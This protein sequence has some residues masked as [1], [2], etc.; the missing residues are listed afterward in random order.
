MTKKN[1]VIFAVFTLISAIFSFLCAGSFLNF[2][3]AEFLVAAFVCVVF[4]ACTLP[5]GGICVALSVAAAFLGGG[6]QGVILA[7]VSGIFAA[8][9]GVAIKKGITTGKLVIIF[10]SGLFFSAIAFIVYKTNITDPKFVENFLNA[11]KSDFIYVAVQY[12]EII[13]VEGQDAVISQFADTYFMYVQNTI[14]AILIIVSLIFAF[15]SSCVVSL[16]LRVVKNRELYKVTFSKFMCDK[17][18]T[19]VFAI[20]AVCFFFM[21]QSI[22]QTVFMNAFMILLFVFQVCGYSLIDSFLKRKNLP[23]GLRFLI[24]VTAMVFLSGG[25]AVSVLVIAAVMDS[26]K[27]FRAIGVEAGDTDEGDKGSE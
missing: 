15:L 6:I 7:S 11:V 24:V 9:A 17:T 19:V 21:K 14:P 13:G 27:N 3:G 18:T 20:S 8:F 23:T 12:M 22:I 16:C 2:Y 1:I 5:L 4:A 25:I 26:F 10:A